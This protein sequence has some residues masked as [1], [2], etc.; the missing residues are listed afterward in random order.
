MIGCTRLL[1]GSATVSE[2]LGHGRRF[3]ASPGALHYTETRGPLVVWNVTRRCNL[4]CEHCYYD[5]ATQSAAAGEFTREEG[6]NLIADLAK[7]GVPVL[8]FSG[9]E[10][11]LRHELFDWG[12]AAR[13]ARLHPVLSTNGVLITDAVARSLADAGFGYVGV[14]LDGM[15]ETNDRFRGLAGAFDAA[16]AG[17][18]AAMR[19]GLR[20]GVRFTVHAGNVAELPA[21]LDLVEAE[22][23]PRFCLYHLVYSGRGARLRDLDL[24][25]EQRRRLL[26]LIIART[27]DWNRRGVESEILTV[28]NHADGLY[29][30]EYVRKHMPERLAE[31]QRLQRLHGGCSAGTKFAN[32]DSGGNVHPCQFWQHVS[33]GNVRDRAF[34][35]IW[36]DLTKPLLAKLKTKGAN[37]KGERCSRCAHQDLCCGCRVRAEAATGDPWDDDPACYL[38]EKERKD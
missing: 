20:T 9:G 29:I 25:N 34:G 23:I 26:D 27:L 7:A 4:R 2:A 31:V 36:N 16:L 10:P 22:G 21:V 35:E 3:T 12:R 6:M 11:L 14:S 1:C 37:L 30:T 15:R 13:D 24:T 32:I 38:T 5:A 33:L 8:L 28:D 18:R 19:A 17:L